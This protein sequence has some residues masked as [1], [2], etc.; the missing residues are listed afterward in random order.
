MELEVEMTSW[1]RFRRYLVITQF[2]LMGIKV[3]PACGDRRV[4]TQPFFNS[5]GKDLDWHQMFVESL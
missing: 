4:T 1:I 2:R 5:T 3:E